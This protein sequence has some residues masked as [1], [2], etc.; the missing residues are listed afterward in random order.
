MFREN[1]RRLT[2]DFFSSFYWF[3]EV[4]VFMIEVQV[5]MVQLRHRTKLQQGLR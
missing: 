2:D 5:T 4:A 1:V 3:I